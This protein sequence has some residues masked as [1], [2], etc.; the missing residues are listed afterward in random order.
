M[1]FLLIFSHSAIKK[2]QKWSV[3]RC[4]FCSKSEISGKA[5]VTQPA[6]AWGRLCHLVCNTEQRRKKTTQLSNGEIFD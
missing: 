6:P 5:K 4:S 2:Q 3:E 1:N